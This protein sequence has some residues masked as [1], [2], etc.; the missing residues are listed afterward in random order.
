M[1]GPGVPRYVNST[2]W[3]HIST[4]AGRQP[5]VTMAGAAVALEIS[6]SPVQCGLGVA[7]RS[8]GATLVLVH[9][10][11]LLSCVASVELLVSLCLEFWLQSVGEESTSLTAPRPR[12]DLFYLHF[13]KRKSTLQGPGHYVCVRGCLFCK[14]NTNA[15]GSEQRVGDSAKPGQG[16][17][18]EPGLWGPQNIPVQARQGLDKFSRSRQCAY[19]CLN[20][21]N[22][23]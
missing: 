15:S 17:I 18:E 14:Y 8:H 10:W 23:A 13:G 4:S 20:P 5:K 21:G 12:G 3:R 19:R 9:A 22:K 2:A 6:L 16:E 11:P 7:P 1:G